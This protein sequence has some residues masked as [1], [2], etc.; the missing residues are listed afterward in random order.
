MGVGGA[1]SWRTVLHSTVFLVR[2]IF[3]EQLVM[4]SRDMPLRRYIIN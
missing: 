1:K 3:E 4:T 2:Y